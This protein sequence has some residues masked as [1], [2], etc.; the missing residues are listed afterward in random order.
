MKKT[1]KLLTLAVALFAGLSGTAQAE[2]SSKA[3]GFKLGVDVVSSFVWRG[4]AL[5][6]SPSIQPAV[7]YTFP[8]I[9]VVVGAW[10]TNDVGE[11][12]AK[13]YKETDLYVTVPVGPVN[14]TLTDYYIPSHSTSSKAFD[15]K[16]DGPN[17]LDL[18]AAYDINDF[19]LLGSV[20]VGGHTFS[21]AKYF[22]VGYKFHQ[23]DKYTAKAVLGLGDEGVYALNKGTNNFNLVNLGCTVSKDNFSAGYIYNP[24]NEESNL[25]FSASF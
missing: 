1:A 16:S 3:E 23:K 10:G 24:A 12:G 14:V 19:T 9:G 2:S 4:S 21:N 7:S 25:V 18:T 8:G 22:E 15:F 6:Q 17:T 11:V 5:S 20:Y 13:R